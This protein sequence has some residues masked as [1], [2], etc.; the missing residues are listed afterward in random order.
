[1]GVRV[2]KFV[3]CL[4][5]GFMLVGDGM[6]LGGFYLEWGGGERGQGLSLFRLVEVEGICEKRSVFILEQVFFMFL[7]FFLIVFLGGWFQFLFIDREL[8]FLRGLMLYSGYTIESLFE[9]AFFFGVCVLSIIIG[10]LLG[11]ECGF[12]WLLWRLYIFF[13]DIFVISSM[14]LYFLRS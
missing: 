10:V 1:M 4:L 11:E 13:N 7:S 8:A 3:W 14:C 9:F 12:F 2:V 5:G 6:G